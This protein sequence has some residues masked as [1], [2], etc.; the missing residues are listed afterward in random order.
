M[1]KAKTQAKRRAMSSE[2]ASLKKIGGHITEHDFAEIIGGEVNL[3][4]Q[5]AKKDVIDKSHRTHSVKGGSY[6]Q[7]FLYRRSHW[8]NNTVFRGLGDISKIMIECLDCFPDNRDDYEKDKKKYKKLLQEPMRK[9]LKELSKEKI[10]PAFLSKAIFNDGEVDYL[11]IKRDD[12]SFHVFA[13]EDVLPVLIKSFRLQN[14]IARNSK[15]HSD[16]KVVLRLE[17]GDGKIVNAGEIEVRNDSDTHYREMKC[18]FTSRLIYELLTNK[19]TYKQIKHAKVTA[20]GRA[21]KT[22]NI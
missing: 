8:E 19:I 1:P 2:T 5:Q 18:R 4:N 22:F 15:Q 21:I 13:K 14:S 3:G 20:Y 12:G 10:L 9:L 16:Q 6:W 7:I 11:T 17:R